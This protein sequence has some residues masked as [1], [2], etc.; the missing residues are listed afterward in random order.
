MPSQAS[1]NLTVFNSAWAGR[2]FR[3][4]KLTACRKSSRV[5]SAGRVEVKAD[6]NKN[7]ARQSLPRRK[8]VKRKWS[9]FAQLQESGSPGSHGALL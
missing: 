1:E 8:R 4:A 5:L 6:R 2:P 3:L 7:A 9:L